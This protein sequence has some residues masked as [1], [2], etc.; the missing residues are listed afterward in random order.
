MSPVPKKKTSDAQNRKWKAARM[1]AMKKDADAMKKYLKSVNSNP[2]SSSETIRAET[3]EEKCI[4]HSQFNVQES[5]QEKQRD[6]NKTE[7][8]YLDQNNTDA[9]SDRGETIPTVGAGDAISDPALWP[10]LTPR[11]EIC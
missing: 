1:T 8:L 2:C 6:P 4:G 7:I 9:T 10:N 5:L 3:S 11:I